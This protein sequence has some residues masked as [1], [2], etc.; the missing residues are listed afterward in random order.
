M[1]KGLSSPSSFSTFFFLPS[2]DRE[3]LRR[4]DK[5]THFFHITR[6]STY[7]FPFSRLGFAFSAG[8]D[9]FCS[10]CDCSN[11][12]SSF[13]SPF[14][15]F[16]SLSFFLGSKNERYLLLLLHFFLSHLPFFTIS[17]ELYCFCFLDFLRVLLC[18]SSVQF[19][20]V[21]RNPFCFFLCFFCALSI[22]F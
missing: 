15:C 21:S 5:N 16:F 10:P 6:V 8:S 2:N 3:R 20:C 7:C 12:M 9:G 18:F 11:G 14:F 1:T 4:R 22:P 17:S 13:L 19:Q